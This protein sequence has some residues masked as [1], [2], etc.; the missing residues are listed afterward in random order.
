[1]SHDPI[2]AVLAALERRGFDPR[3]VGADSWDSRCPA[4]DGERR[5][6]S[7]K[8]GEDGR[9]LLHCNA[10]DCDYGDIMAA[11]SL[12]EGDGFPPR[13]DRPARP[14]VGLNGHA[15]PKALAKGGGKPKRVYPTPEAATA[16]VRRDWG[17]PTGEWPYHDA[18]GTEVARVCRF[19]R[20]GGEK[21]YRPVH[22]TP[23]GWVNGDPPGLWPLYRLLGIARA[24]RVD[25]VLICE[26]EKAADAARGLGL[27]ATTSAHGAKSPHKTD[28][29]PLAGK[30]VVILPDHDEAGEAYARDL[31][32]LLA[33]LNPRPTVRIVRLDSNQLW[34]NPSPIP[35][36]ADIVDWLETPEIK[37]MS[38]GSQRAMLEGIANEAAPVDFDTP[39]PAEARD[40]TETTLTGTGWP[41]PPK[42]AAFDG[43]A[44]KIVRAIEPHTE[45]DP[46][47]ILAQLLVGFGNLI[48][49][50]AH[51]AVEASRHYT[52]QFVA[53][54]GATA[55]G[56]K[57]TSWDHAKRLLE[58]ID[59]TWTANRVL[60]G[61]STGEGLIHAVRDP[62]TKQ[63]PIKKGKR[64]IDYQD[65]E[66][67]AGE[68]D[69][70]ALCIES[71]LG[72]TL[73]V[74]TRNGN[75]LS[76]LVRQ[77]WDSGDL[78]TLTRENSLRS[79][80][81]HVSIVG[82]ITKDELTTALTRTDAANGFANRFL[83]LAVRRSKIL[84]FGGNWSD[85]DVAL[86]SKPLRAAAHF[87]RTTGRMDRDDGANKLWA[88]VYHALSEG[89]PGLLG[90]VTSRAEAHVMRLAMLYALIDQSPVI[91]ADHLRSALALWEFSERSAAYIF[92]D[93]LGDPDADTLLDAIRSAPEGLTRTE[94]RERVFQKNRPAESIE[95]M[96][97]KL[98]EANLAHVRPEDTGGRPAERWFAGRAPAK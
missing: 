73:R 10:H 30:N 98:T 62:A 33:K 4:H 23:Q 40:V 72:G 77:A 66:V 35:K 54:V 74:A 41:D 34:I 42:A 75:N 51:F 27:V 25:R 64:V 61:L 79:T 81:A 5:N 43:L 11:L 22:L 39:P 84:P 7:I 44:G 69:K 2:E 12:T 32:G 20:L 85:S 9:V 90:A 18:S 95:R 52:N 53:L 86:W 17:E 38:I 13:D 47:A 87:A 31:V 83:W 63:E 58:A 3:T 92:G 28:W 57:G 97:R 68:S 78:G 48:G 26:G 71:E 56:R 89:R 8:R 59:P 55:K 80:G 15:K 16:W 88:D 91:R 45:A 60:F 19:D 96:L 37:G 6:L 94:I 49:R 36:G 65:V 46:V 50:S 93:S 82:H 67:D 1:M 76:A 14:R 29:S 70:R 21:T 24:D